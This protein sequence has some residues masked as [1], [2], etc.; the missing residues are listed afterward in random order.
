MDKFG[1]KLVKRI[2]ISA[3]S[4]HNRQMGKQISSGCMTVRFLPNNKSGKIPSRFK[5]PHLNA[6]LLKLGNSK[7]ISYLSHCT[8][9][10]RCW[11]TWPDGREKIF[12]L[13]IF[14]NDRSST[15]IWHEG[16]LEKRLM[17]F[18]VCLSKS[19]L[20]SERLCQNFHHHH[21]TGGVSSQWPGL[22]ST[23]S[24]LIWWLGGARWLPHW[25]DKAT[26]WR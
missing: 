11:L 8:I 21:H 3:K 10:I 13:K 12:P 19:L 14:H 6:A 22:A 26:V 16:V 25:R 24:L 7:W 17:L 18:W 20:E 4:N 2:Q 1:G 15:L 5:F 23:A 9:N